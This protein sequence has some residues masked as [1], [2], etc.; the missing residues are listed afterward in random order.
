MFSLNSDRPIII[1]G[2]CSAESPEQVLSIFQKLSQDKRIKCVRAGVWKPRTRPDS[3]EGSGAK[4]LP[5]LEEASKITGLPVAVEVANPQHVDACLKHNIDVMWIGA[6]TTVSPFA[7]QDIANSLKGVNIPL[8][9][10]NP[11]NPDIQLWLGAIERFEKAGIAELAAV[12]RGFSFYGDSPYR[13]VPNWEIPIE[14]KRVRSDIPMFCDPSHIGG[15]SSLIQG[16]CQKALN[17]NFDGLMIESHPNPSVALSDPAQQ[18]TPELLFNIL[19]NLIVRSDQDMSPEFSER[20]QA[21]RQQIDALDNELFD[22]LLQRMKIAEIIGEAKRDNSVTILKLR[23]WD[24]IVTERIKWGVEMGFSKEF[25]KGI[26]QLI[27]KES[28]RIQ[29]DVM[30]D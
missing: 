30:N 16:I 10:K 25:V 13:N 9:V 3:F 24:Q 15:Q 22:K 6:R 17:L 18:V 7:V 23:R 19:D 27:H 4:A 8:L 20:I 1:A 29:N 2:P 5:W 28:I 14:F 11:V 12:H 26:M 21:L